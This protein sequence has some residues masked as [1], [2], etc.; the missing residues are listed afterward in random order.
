AASEPARSERDLRGVLKLEHDPKS[1][2]P[3]RSGVDYG[4]SEKFMLQSKSSCSNQRSEARWRFNLIQSRQSHRASAGCALGQDA[5][6][7][8][9]VHVEAP[10]CLR[11]V[12]TAQ[13]IDALDVLPA[14]TV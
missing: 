14:D 4:F 1:L 10:R 8:A 7:G 13:F 11:H 3:T 5:L 2:P 12:A 6:Q 9:A